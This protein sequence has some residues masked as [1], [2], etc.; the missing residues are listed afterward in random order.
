MCRDDISKPDDSAPGL[1]VPTC[2]VYTLEFYGCA[3][4]VNSVKMN[5]DRDLKLELEPRL[6]SHQSQYPTMMGNHMMVTRKAKCG[7]SFDNDVGP[8]GGR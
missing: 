5:R 7:K 3:E 8:G 1:L 6:P 4:G 2:T